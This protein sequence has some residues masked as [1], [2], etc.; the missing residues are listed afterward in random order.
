MH[1]AALRVGAAALLCTVSCVA[2]ELPG[3]QYWDRYPPLP[4]TSRYTPESLVRNF[5]VRSAFRPP[6]PAG[7]PRHQCV[8]LF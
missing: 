8:S 2:V 7:A 6:A 1:G 4:G 3:T 5:E